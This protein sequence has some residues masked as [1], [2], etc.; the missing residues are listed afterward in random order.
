MLQ[1]W[2]KH[3]NTVTVYCRSA[4]NT[5]IISGVHIAG[6]LQTPQ[7]C[8]GCMYAAGMVQT[9]QSCQCMFAGVLQTPINIRGAYCRNAS[10]T[11]IMSGVC[12]YC[13][14]GSNIPVYVCRSTPIISGVC[15]VSSNE[16]PVVI[17]CLVLAVNIAGRLQTPQSCQ[18]VCM[19]QECFKHPNTVSVCLQEQTP[20]NI[21]GAYCRN[22][23]NT[24]IMSR[25][26]VY[27]RK[28]SNIPILSVY[29]AGVLQTPQ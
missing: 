1:E 19:L 25:V 9:S 11:P 24:P 4:S 3:P 18:G 20:I 6:M 29:V 21:R 23:S 10:N 16:P 5:P 17:V 13:R 22:A 2:F 14:N 7:S 12:V 27:C 28:A 8:Q 15:A 26:Y